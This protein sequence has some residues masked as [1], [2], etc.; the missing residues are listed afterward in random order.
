MVLY[1]LPSKKLKIISS[2]PP[3]R[4]LYAAK[5]NPGSLIGS[6]GA[7]RSPAI[8]LLRDVRIPDCSGSG[9][10]S[11]SH[12]FL[13]ILFRGTPS[14][15]LADACPM[16]EVGSGIG[17]AGPR[18]CAAVVVAAASRGVLPSMMG[19]DIVFM[20]WK[21]CPMEWFRLHRALGF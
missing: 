15:R 13:L 21:G 10:S 20:L 5:E 17:A 19:N 6:R 2:S 1:I 3:K 16:F 12:T 9:K 18:G 14:L 4:T 8:L 7:M 11:Q